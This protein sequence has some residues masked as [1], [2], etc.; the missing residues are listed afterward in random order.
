VLVD[1][2]VAVL[3]VHLHLRQHINVETST[4]KTVAEQ[5]NS[6]YKTGTIV[7]EIKLV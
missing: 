6:E 3:L 7:C 2:E 5:H 1:H 4:E